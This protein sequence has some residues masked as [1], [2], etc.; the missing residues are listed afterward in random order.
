MR[1]IKLFCLFLLVISYGTYADTIGKY[2]KI[3]KSIPEMSLKADPKAQ[4][5]M[6]S[7]QSVLAITD[8]TVAQTIMAMNNVAKAQGHPLICLAESQTIDGSMVHNI[9]AEK[10]KGDVDENA[11]ETI[12]SIVTEELIKTYPCHSVGKKLAEVWP[13][14]KVKKRIQLQSER[15]A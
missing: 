3:A 9:L 14:I 1:A 8:E 10:I 13:G 2:A 15:R 11:P 12:S 7:A 4:A 6:R 5:W